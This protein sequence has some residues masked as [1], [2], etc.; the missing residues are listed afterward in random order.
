MSYEG[1]RD[2]ISHI[3]AVTTCDILVPVILAIAIKC[4][5]IEDDDQ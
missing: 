5:G 2:S 3:N 4:Q 1:R